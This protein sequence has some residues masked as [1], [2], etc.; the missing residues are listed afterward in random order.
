[1]HLLQRSAYCAETTRT[2]LKDDI[3]HLCHRHL[4]VDKKEIPVKSR[5]VSWNSWESLVHKGSR[6]KNP[7]DHLDF[8]KLD[9]MTRTYHYGEFGQSEKLDAWE[10][11]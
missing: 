3:E 8:E 9:F 2:G 5:K 4:W 1:M 10:L 11:I 7:K 6:V